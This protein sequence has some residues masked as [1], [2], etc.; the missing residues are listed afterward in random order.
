MTPLL[1]RDDTSRQLLKDY[2]DVVSG[3][4]R[5]GP[6]KQIRMLNEHLAYDQH[7]AQEQKPTPGHSLRSYPKGT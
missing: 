3:K 5:V 6:A 1:E 7:L 2:Q 4:T